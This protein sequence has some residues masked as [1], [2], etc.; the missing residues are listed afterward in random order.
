MKFGTIYARDI[1]AAG[2]LAGGFVLIA[3]GVDSFVT[4]TMTLILGYYFSKRVFEEKAAAAT[5][6]AP[7][8]AP[9][10]TPK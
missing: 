1:I 6:A 3:R 9:A 7:A 2:C 4:A 8:A 5:P 10:L